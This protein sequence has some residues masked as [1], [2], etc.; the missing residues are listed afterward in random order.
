MGKGTVMKIRSWFLFFALV[1]PLAAEGPTAE[2]RA[3][4]FYLQGMAAVQAGQVQTAR[5]AFSNALRFNPKHPH[6]RYQLGEL[7]RIGEGV[8]GKARERKLAAVII[9]EI[10]FDDSNLREVLEGLD[11]L[12][13]KNSPDQYTANFVVQD[14]GKQFDKIP[15]TIQLRNVPASTVLKYALEQVHGTAKYDEHAIVIKPM[16]AV[17]TGGQ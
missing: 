11:L 10:K 16:P 17:T 4:Q 6:A 15:V 12:V 2:A 3:E 5:T 13:R 1:M 14:P 7:Q 9:P 8:A